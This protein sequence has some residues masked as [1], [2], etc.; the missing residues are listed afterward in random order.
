M[1][2]IIS[3]NSLGLSN[4]S[5]A[6]LGGQGVLGSAPNGRS[7]ENVYVDS[8]TGNLVLQNRDELLLG[9]GFNIGLVRT[10]NSQGLLDG[11][12]NDNWR[13]GV[14]KKVSGLT[15]TV[16]TAG[17]TVRRTEGDGA[18]SV[19]TFNATLG[20]YVSSDGGGAF[21]TLSFNAASQVWT[22]TD[23]SSQA[24]EL[25]DNA[26]GGRITSAQD[27]DGNSLSY[28]YN[29]AGLI[30]QVTDA[31]GESTF[32]DYTGTNL[33]QI[34]TVMGAS[35]LT[36]VRYGYDASN[37][38]STVTVDLSPQDNS[39]ADGRTY[40]TTYTYDG[41]STRVASMAQSDGTRL[42]FTY[43]QVG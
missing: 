17:S 37:R 32:L 39:I 35:T 19:F 9:R 38:L 20:V 11:D 18:E 2:A 40:V 13:L 10:Y 25:Y 21:D 34:R 43:V 6:T 12:N 26:N 36:R 5:L 14:Y 15:G 8:V 24:K 23:G 27:T 29:A 30:T 41:T 1:A 31:S 4:S 22:F 7:G 28:T 42:T 16:N 33:T 3:G